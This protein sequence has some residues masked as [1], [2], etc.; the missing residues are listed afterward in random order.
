[1]K[2][3]YTYSSKVAKK[4]LIKKKPKKAKCPECKSSKLR[5]DATLGETFCAKCGLVVE[6][7]EMDNSKYGYK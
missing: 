3:T 6:D 7:Q 1:M 5:Y 4:T 2:Y